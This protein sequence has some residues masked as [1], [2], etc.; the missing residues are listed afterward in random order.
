VPSRSPLARPAGPLPA[1]VY[2]L[3]RTVVLV[4][5]VVL[6]L[7]LGSFLTRS[8]DG[9]DSGDAD[10]SAVRAGFDD[11]S[12]EPTTSASATASA[13]PGDRTDAATATRATPA[14]KKKQKQ[15]EPLAAPDGP[16]AASDVV[17]EPRV[18]DAV[19]GRDVRVRL[20][21]RTTGREACSWQVSPVT[22]T[23][24]ITS[25]SD[26][27]WFSRECPS[28]LPE[29]DVVVRRAQDTKVGFDWNG[30]RSDDECSNL[31]EWALPGWYHIEAAAL[32][33]EPR[34]R[35][36]ELETPAPTTETASPKNRKK[37]E[38]GGRG[39]DAEPGDGESAP[40]DGPAGPASGATEPSG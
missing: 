32:A 2:W 26:D 17:V 7:L 5:P 24:K 39:A 6:V 19:A 4:V 40:T 34:D 25:G 33:G 35:Q 18:V 30:K 11:A 27:I 31:V 28:A 21:L 16:C 37:A 14:T 13:S 22:L 20:L 9:S 10:A 3:R 12:D 29:T 8:S 38:D 15:K 23:V 1:R 36:F